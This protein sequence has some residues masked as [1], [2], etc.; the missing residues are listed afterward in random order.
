MVEDEVSISNVLTKILTADP[1]FHKVW[2]APDGRSAID[3]LDRESFDLVSLDYVM[4]G[5]INGL[6]VYNHIRKTQKTLPVLFI[7]G[8]IRFIE[9]MEQIRASDSYMDHLSKPFANLSYAD[10]VN[11][12]L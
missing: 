12:W 11:D 5:L 9:S 1:F 6:D 8:N 10:K 7:S 3:L 4:P 2:V